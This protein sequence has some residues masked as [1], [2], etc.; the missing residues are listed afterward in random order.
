MAKIDYHALGLKTQYTFD[1]LIIGPSNHIPAKACLEVVKNPGEAYNPLYIY[2]DTGV[3]KTH[4]AQ[5]VAHAMLKANPKM[6]VKY[7][8]SE[9]FANEIL[10]AIAEDNIMS[11][12]DHYSQLD[13]WI[14]GDI[15]YLLE[16]KA[17]QSE[18]FHI[19]N[20]LHQDNRQI[21]ITSDRPPSKLNGF[22]KTIRTRLEWGLATDMKIPD[23]K[24]RLE[25]LQ[26]KQ[27]KIWNSF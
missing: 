23:I 16:S 5:A 24:E 3:G 1:D 10:S 11:V 13:L 22:D 26:I 14:L 19:F 8:S 21:L 12:R 20:I 18:F 25:I 15:Q 2:G 7:I 6:K 27:K 17:A 9:R 4:L